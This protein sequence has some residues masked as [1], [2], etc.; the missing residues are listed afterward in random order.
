M[1][2]FADS[3]Y[4]TL[5]LISILTAWALGNN[6]CWNKNEG[7]C[8]VNKIDKYSKDANLYH[9][10]LELFND[11]KRNY[12]PCEESKCSC[13]ASVIGED[14]KPFS[15]GITQQM[16]EQVKS[17]GT[18]YQIINNQ[19]YRDEYCMFPARCQGVEHFLL[20]L[21]SKLPDVEFILNTRDWPQIHKKGGI[22]S[23]VFSFSKTSDYYDIMYPAWSFWEG[24]PAISLYPRGIGRWDM[25]RNRLGKLGN[26][27][28]WSDKLSK[29]FFR[30]SRTS[31][32]RDPLILLSREN[33]DMVD[34]SYTKNQAWK[35]D[36]DTLHAPPAKEVSFEEHCQYKYLFNFRGVA[37]SFRF[38]HMFLCK[39]LVF[40][41]GDDWQE[42]FYAS[43][44]PWVHY[45]PI[46]ANASKQEIQEALEFAINNDDIAKE[47]AENGYKFI[48]NNLKMSD[49][50]CYWKKLI[51][52]Y[53]K[54]LT[55]KPSL[56][57]KMIH[58]KE[59]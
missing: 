14:L 37:A 47:I 21:L 36:A 41:V 19:L 52:R 51:K 39:S 57:K 56:D 8:G 34:A 1:K 43:L 31:S 12:I 48:W 30:G 6:T 33:P 16:M 26:S 28:K 22:V 3:I 15:N 55:Y 35:S 38:K 54:H 32:E 10:Y 46:K 2:H 50:R 24:G 27:T 40:H 53:A 20:E 58:I 25:H 45:I 13:Y 7:D 59:K 18:K 42:F 5:I 49:V 9:K 11:A 17:K 4:T 44:K 29:A 23:P